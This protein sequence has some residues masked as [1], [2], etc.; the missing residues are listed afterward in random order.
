MEAQDSTLKPAVHEA[1]AP[2]PFLNDEERVGKVAVVTDSASN[3]PLDIIAEYGISVIPIYLHWNG[4]TY[5]D[6]VD[7]K[8]E[9]VYRRLRDSQTTPQ[10]AAPSVGDFLQTYLKLAEEVE[11]IVSIHLPENLS[12]VITAARMASELAIKEVDVRVVD[13]GTAAMGA[14]FVTLAAARAAAQGA[15]LE[16]VF[17]VAQEVAPKVTVVAMLDTLKYLHRS[18][19]ISTVTALMGIA[20]KIKPIMYIK[21][22]SIQVFAKPRTSSRGIRLMLA[23]MERQ[24]GTDPTHVAVL[25][26]DAPL[27]AIQLQKEVEMRVNCIEVFTCAFTPVMGAHTGPGLLGIAFYP[28]RE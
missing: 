12:G 21:D 15:D 2:K 24:V 26:A 5:R 10:T 6:G 4:R 25:H 3:L 19:R 17:G 1:A 22:H 7:I 23:E 8:P 18:G 14:G 11:G 16:D 9:E 27:E 13:A 20:L 28:E